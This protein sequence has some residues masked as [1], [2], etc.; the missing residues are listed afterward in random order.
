MVLRRCRWFLKDEE[1]AM[2]AT[3]DVFVRLIKYSKKIDDRAL[4]SLLMR[5]ATQ[6]SLNHIRSRQRKPADHDQDLLMRIASAPLEPRVYARLFL[7]RL[8]EQE[9]DTTRAMAVM[10][11]LDGM[12]LEEV[13]REVNMSVSG[14][15]KRLRR[16]K[17][18]LIELEKVA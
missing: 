8:F 3:Q 9:R 15:R 7:G 14:V 11:L 17:K 6:V 4:A 2:D 10:H 16:L 1:M 5:V 12:S 13:A 18:S